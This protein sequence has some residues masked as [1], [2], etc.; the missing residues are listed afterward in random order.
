MNLTIFA[1]HEDSPYNSELTKQ[2]ELYSKKNNENIIVQEITKDKIESIVSDKSVVKFLNL[3]I[4]KLKKTF[5]KRILKKILRIYKKIQIKKIAHYAVFK[6]AD[7]INIHFVSTFKVRFAKYIIKINPKV[8]FVTTVWGSDYLRSNPEKLKNNAFIYDKSEVIT[9][10]NHEIAKIFDDYFK[11]KYSKKIKIL[12]F[13]LAA[14][15]SIEKIKNEIKKEDIIKN[16]RIE[17]K[18]IICIGTNA[19]KEQQHIKVIDEIIHLPKG[20]LKN[21]KF[22]FHMS[23]GDIENKNIVIN[24]LLL[25]SLDYLIIDNWLSIEKLSEIRIMSDLLIQVQKTDQFS[26]AMQEAIFA[27]NIIITGSW[28]PYSFLI[29]KGV[30]FEQM[31]SIGDINERIISVLNNIDQ[32]EQTIKTNAKI[33]WELSSW[34]N[35]IKNWIDIYNSVS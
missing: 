13:G 6:D 20:V 12:R 5:I 8:R 25:S 31:D 23:Y 4:S 7:I 16:F 1:S 35:T 34:N 33:I 15:D 2:I 22:I 11:Q 27:G 32:N 30:Y 28:L 29:K 19:T 24:R 9:F 26:G 3:V 21:I 10:N 17:K 18:Y 14:L